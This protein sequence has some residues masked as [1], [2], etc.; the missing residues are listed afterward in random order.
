MYDANR[1][2]TRTPEQLIADY[3]QWTIDHPGTSPRSQIKKNGKRLILTELRK[4][5]EQG[6]KQAANL[7]DELELGQ[8][9]HQALH[10]WLKTLP[11]EYNILK[12]LYDENRN[13]AA[14]KTTDDLYQDLVTHIRDY[15]HYPTWEESSLYINIYKRLYSNQSTMTTDG[16]YTDSP[17]ALLRGK[18]VEINNQ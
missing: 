10:N 12:P 5:A 13:R 16:K 18:S 3:K 1:K 6:D 7:A 2:N 17:I 15:G 9:I 8:N 11:E 4:R 14:S